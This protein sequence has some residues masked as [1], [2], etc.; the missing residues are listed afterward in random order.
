MSTEPSSAS[1]HGPTEPVTRCTVAVVVTLAASIALPSLQ[2]LLPVGSPWAWRRLER[3]V[4]VALLL[5]LGGITYLSRLAGTVLLPPP[6][7]SIHRVLERFPAPLFAALAAASSMGQAALS[8]WASQPIDQDGISDLRGKSLSD[9]TSLNEFAGCFLQIRFSSCHLCYL[10]PR[11]FEVVDS[12]LQFAP[13]KH[14]LGP[15]ACACTFPS[16][17]GVKRCSRCLTRP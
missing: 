16:P 7:G 4:S 1:P 3:G 9:P 12:H 10:L 8:R 6:R 5:I 15:A 11:I 2:P 13:A 14:R 17:V